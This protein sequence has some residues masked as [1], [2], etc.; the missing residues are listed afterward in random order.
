MGKVDDVILKFEV[1]FLPVDNVQNLV[2]AK[3]TCDQLKIQIG[4][5]VYLYLHYFL[6]RHFLSV[7]NV[8]VSYHMGFC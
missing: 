8:Q 6:L 2:H 4:L 3:Q 7:I 5:S 1:M